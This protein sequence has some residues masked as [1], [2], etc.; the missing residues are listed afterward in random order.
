MGVTVWLARWSRQTEEEQNRRH[1]VVVLAVLAAG[2]VLVSMFRAILTF[3]SLVRVRNLD[4]AS[5]SPKIFMAGADVRIVAGR[6]GLLLSILVLSTVAAF[7]PVGRT[8]VFFYVLLF[9]FRYL[10]V[11]CS[12][13]E[14]AAFSR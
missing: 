11:F 1:Y 8:V 2:A 10:F 13:C 9:R 4:T 12:Q 3:F 5:L 6:K 14:F 7:P